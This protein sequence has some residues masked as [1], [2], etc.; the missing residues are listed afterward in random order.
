M[1]KVQILYEICLF[2]GKLPIASGGLAENAKRL[3]PR[4]FELFWQSRKI[5]TLPMEHKNHR[6]LPKP[7]DFFVTKIIPR[8][9]LAKTTFFDS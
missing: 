9:E 6:P 4:G 7:Q 3:Q 1:K 8:S 5:A 2:D